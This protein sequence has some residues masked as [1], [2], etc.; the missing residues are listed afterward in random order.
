MYIQTQY[1]N[2]IRETGQG[3]ICSV[4]SFGAM[5]R[6]ALGENDWSRLDRAISTRFAGYVS[7]QHPLR[8]VGRMQWVYCS[9]VGM[10]VAKLIKRFSILPDICARDSEFSFAI[11]GSNGGFLKQR[12][13]QLGQGRRF[14]FTSRFSDLPRLHEEFGG[15][16]GMY[17]RLVVK[18]GALL[19]RDQGYFLRVLRWRVPLPRWLTVGRFELLHR[20]IDARRF[21][22]IIRVSHP[23]FGTLF[24]QRGEF[25]SMAG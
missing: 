8:F 10:F 22:V 6:D 11:S 14:L 23:W 24:Y 19:F 4:Q 20:N 7:E 12:Q 3:V 18:R 17:L 21:Q 13:Y 15:G 9:P 1:V 16:L 2:G 5:L 25:E